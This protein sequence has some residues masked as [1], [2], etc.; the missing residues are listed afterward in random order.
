MPEL[1]TQKSQLQLST[2]ELLKKSEAFFSDA[3]FEQHQRIIQRF[4]RAK[5]IRNIPSKYYDGMDY[6]SD[7]I[8]N[9]NLKNTYLTPKSNQSEVRVNTGTS[10][11]KLDAVK[12][13]LLTINFE[14]EVKAYDEDDLEIEQLGEDMQDMVHRSEEMEK[15]DDVWDEILDE[16]LT[17]RIVYVRETF[18]P[19]TI[20]RGKETISIAKKE[21][22]SGLKV[23]PGDMT[24]PAYLWDTQPYV[25]TVDDVNYEYAKS[26]F[27][28]LPNF[29]HVFPN[30]TERAVYMGGAFSYQFGELQDGRCEII[31]YASLPDDEY[32]VV[33][34]GV[35]MYEPKTEL[36][37]SYP[38]YNIKAFTI[39]AMSRN[40]LPGRPL[41]AMAK[42]MQALSNETIR[43]FIRK[44]QQSLEPPMASP[45]GG[46][47][48]S[49]NIFNPAAWTQGLRKSDFEKLLDHQGVTA[50][51]M[52]MYKIIEQQVETFI[53]TPNVAQGI[54]GSREMSATEVLTVT[55]QFL[56]QLGSTIAALMRIKRDLTEM[57]TYTL[58]ENYLDPTKRKYDE[59][60][61]EIEDVYRSFTINNK[62][63]NHN[64]KG[65]KIIKLF[66]RDIT[67]QEQESL[68]QFEQDQEAQ[69]NPVKIRFINV[70]KLAKIPILWYYNTTIQD[71]EGTALD[72]VTFQDQLN[73]AAGI[74]K[75]TGKPLNANVVTDSF[76]RKW[77]AKD[78]FNVP[79]PEQSNQPPS[80]MDP[81]TQNV[82]SESQDL[83][84]EIE[85]M[86]DQGS[87]GN[88]ISR[89]TA[90]GEKSAMQSMGAQEMATGV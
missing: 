79:P 76:E 17:Q 7:Y 27:G 66:P 88:Q 61:K 47:I 38:A 44:T 19:R 56:K 72:K 67:T 82:Q 62:S 18:Q 20:K 85:K 80:P 10:E 69:G 31:T 55:K 14:T 32:Q 51:E 73:Q 26:L 83:L 21:L 28:H 43:L 52:E 36:P 34:N 87:M 68:H 71:K 40:F 70:K 23:F 89:G 3:Q 1:N 22:V 29:D 11:K 24:I 45:K 86:S 75:L 9:E 50:G 57:R 33:I 12:N 4:E 25:V 54:Q 39:K 64:V 60:S 59:Y 78:W 81:N 53:G 5:Q 65:K 6:V 16:A 46:K 63:L 49:R 41:T 42:S 48:F 13:E 2:E 84:K 77:K 74:L 8:S 58:L 35:P 15:E 90:S 37:W 30:K